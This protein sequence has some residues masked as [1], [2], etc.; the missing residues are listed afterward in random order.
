MNGTGNASSSAGAAALASALASAS[1]PKPF[2]PEAGVFALL[3][4]M[5]ALE[6]CFGR[7]LRTA[8]LLGH[9]LAGVALGPAGLDL[10]PYPAAWGFVGKLGVMLLVL[11]SGLG[12]DTRRVRADGARAFLA[13][14]SGTAFPVALALLGAVGIFGAAAET[15]LAAGSAIAPTSLGFSAKLLGAAGLKT[16]L[17]AI[18]AVAAVVDDVLSLCLL[19]IV[20][21]LGSASSAWD[22]LRPVVAS[23]GSILVGILLVSAIKGGALVAKLAA[24]NSDALLLFAMALLV[25][26]FGW[27]C[28]AVGSS[29]LLG[30]FLAGLAFSGSARS[31]GAFEANFGR[32]T[33]VG[34]SLFFACTVGFGVPPL[35]SS[36]GLFS[37]AAA[38]R[39]AWLLFA[40]LIGK[41][42]PLGLFATPL[43]MG[44]FLKFSVAMQGRGEFSFLIANS[45]Y[46]EGVLDEAWHG[47]A[48][49]AVFLASALAPLAFRW[50]LSREEEE[51]EAEAEGEEAEE[52]K[53]GHGRSGAD[54]DATSERRKTVEMVTIEAVVL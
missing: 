48:I 25:L 42:F 50:V 28:A 52:E 18:I 9:M 22:Y 14:L 16:R 5:F 20:K 27:S 40:A 2:S 44:S 3:L 15:G 4:S 11:E 10:V 39:G 23:L 17:G 54:I 29:D 31:R 12:T 7:A 6:R 53:S 37:A 32:L 1:A 30:C 34:T 38:A 45:A 13:A 8:P 49:W 36:G 41:A 35:G 47:G 43:T 51:E 46:T 24:Y 26:A 33:K 21:A 19:Q